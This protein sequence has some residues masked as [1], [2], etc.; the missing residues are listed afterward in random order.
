MGIFSLLKLL[1]TICFISFGFEKIPQ[2]IPHYL[3]VGND[4]SYKKKLY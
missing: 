3:R 1:K 4:L 2:K